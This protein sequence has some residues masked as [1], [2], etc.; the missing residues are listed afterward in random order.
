MSWIQ[1]VCVVNLSRAQHVNESRR[2]EI[3]PPPSGVQDP[4]MILGKA[5]NMNENGKEQTLETRFFCPHKQCFAFST[6][7]QQADVT[8]CDKC[9]CR[10]FVLGVT[11]IG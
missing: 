3:D 7:P 4:G 10:G 2:A 8:S 1:S 6:S 9:L 5:K 11:L